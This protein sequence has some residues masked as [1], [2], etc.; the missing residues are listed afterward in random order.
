MYILLETGNENSET[1]QTGPKEVN[2][3]SKSY[4]KTSSFLSRI[5]VGTKCIPS[6]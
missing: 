4:Q 3:S 1:K 2:G 6:P 5:I